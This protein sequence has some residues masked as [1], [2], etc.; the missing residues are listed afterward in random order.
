MKV[1]EFIS[2]VGGVGHFP[3]A[4]GTAGSAVGLAAC[5]LLRG[6]VPLYLS[7][8]L[9]FFAAG[10]VAAGKTEKD[11]NMKDPSCVVI[12]EFA[13]IFPVFF[14]LPMTPLVIASGFLLYRGLDILKPPPVSLLEKAGGGW[15]IML[16]DLA[17][18]ILTNIAL[19]LFLFFVS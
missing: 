19:R 8:F 16:D 1:H 4:P 13:G 15:G 17:A 11:R 6:S 3:F 14:L 12:D 5:F 10:V 7:A 18:G 9:V 2:T